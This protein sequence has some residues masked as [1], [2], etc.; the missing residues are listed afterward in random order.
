[1]LGYTLTHT[2]TV[3]A[4][5]PTVAMRF[6]RV[7]Q[8]ATVQTATVLVIRE[9]KWRPNLRRGKARLCPKP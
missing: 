5:L 1:M 3:I 8:T 9:Q 4:V 7:P 2:P 6:G